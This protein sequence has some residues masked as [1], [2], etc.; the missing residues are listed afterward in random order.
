[1]LKYL[2]FNLKQAEL[3]PDNKKLAQSISLGQLGIYIKT[4]TKSSCHPN[5]KLSNI[6]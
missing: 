1:M 2:D 3:L 5:G 6:V 4:V